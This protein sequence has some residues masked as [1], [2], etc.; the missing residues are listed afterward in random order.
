MKNSNKFYKCYRDFLPTIHNDLALRENIEWSNFWWDKADE[1]NTPMR[2]LLIGD[3]TAR[4]VRSTFAKILKRPV[5]MI[6]SSS[7]LNDEL[8]V[9]Q[10]DA[11]FDNT[12]YRYDVIFI[13]M[14]HHGRHRSDGS[15]LNEDDFN[16]FEKSLEALVS[17]LKQFTDKIVLETIF[18]AVKP[19]K[20]SKVD[21]V[22]L[23]GRFHHVLCRIGIRKEEPDESINI[24]TSRKNDI[25]ISLSMN[26]GEKVYLLDIN[27]LV[28]KTNY[29]HI[30]HIHFE[31]KAKGYIANM[32]A[33]ML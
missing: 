9:N 21:R 16:E 18:D 13:Q 31:E 7:I 5:D 19:H 27:K 32:M 8:F 1:S 2:Y 6:G 4:M 30:D 20:I 25:I 14:G 10:I 24:I 33:T 15:P 11:F 22:F 12:L 28:N 23:K 17:Y 29:V 26:L 3:S